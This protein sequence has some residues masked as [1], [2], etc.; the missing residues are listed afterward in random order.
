MKRLLSI[1]FVLFVSTGFSWG[2][3]VWDDSSHEQ[4]SAGNSS[5]LRLQKIRNY[6]FF[7]S[8]IIFPKQKKEVVVWASVNIPRLATANELTGYLENNPSYWRGVT[9]IAP[10]LEQA[11]KDWRDKANAWL[12]EKYY[13]PELKFTLKD[14]YKARMARNV[15]YIPKTLN[16]T[17]EITTGKIGFYKG[18]NADSA[19]GRAIPYFTDDG[20]GFGQIQFFMEEEWMGWLNSLNKSEEEQAIAAKEYKKA[21]SAQLAGESYF[22]SPSSIGKDWDSYLSDDSKRFFNMLSK[23]PVAEWKSKGPWADYHQHV[24]T[25]EVGHLFGLVHINDKSSIMHPSIIGGQ[26]VVRPSSEDGLRLATLVCWYHNQRA[27]KEVCVPLKHSKEEQEVRNRIQSSLKTWKEQPP[28]SPALAALKEMATPST[29]TL[30][31]IPGKPVTRQGFNQSASAET[32]VAVAVPVA[33]TERT[34]AAAEESSTAE[35]APSVLNQPVAQRTA[36]RPAP[37]SGGLTPSTGFVQKIP[38]KTP[39]PPQ[40][41]P[42]SFAKRAPQAVEEGSPAGVAK[43]GAVP[44]VAEVKKPVKKCY[45]CGKELEEGEY[46]S[47][48]ESRHVHKNSKCA[49]QAFAQYHDTSSKALARYEDFYF[50]SIPQDVVQARAD[51]RN[52]GLTVASVRQYAS[53]TSAAQ[54]TQQA[55]VKADIAAMNQSAKERAEKAKKCAFYMVVTREDISRYAAENQEVLRQI[56]KK[57]KGGR[58]LNKQERLVKQNYDQLYKNYELTQYCQEQEK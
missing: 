28:V 39:T 19:R 57:E 52:L 2:S 4:L 12:P 31:E 15:H 38:V 1:L 43:A 36:A 21:A 3:A 11:W 32:P 8:N 50:L 45:I 54:K 53:Q 40:L 56:R 58:V 25:H 47:F 17:L 6:E 49:Y 13:L 35:K 16:L 48:S 14:M 23:I 37:L 34:V 24:V 42:K 55:Q 27:K 51:M 10:Y 26:G 46:Y 5:V 20:N 41:Q 33:T 29:T 22:S 30:P 7:L 18:N 44:P 9:E